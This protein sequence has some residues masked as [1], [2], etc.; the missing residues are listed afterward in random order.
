MI[1]GEAVLV[2]KRVGSK[3]IGGTVF[4][5]GVLYMRATHVGKDSSIARIVD[6]MEKAQ[7]SKAPIQRI[8]GTT[9]STPAA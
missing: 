2:S 4:K 8:A 6:L 9:S 5:V 1:T 3:V 7:M